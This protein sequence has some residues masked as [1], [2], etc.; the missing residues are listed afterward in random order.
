MSQWIPIQEYKISF[1]PKINITQRK[2]TYF[3]IC[4]KLDIILEKKNIFYKCQVQKRSKINLKLKN[5][6]WKSDVGTFWCLAYSHFY[7][8]TYVSLK[9]DNPNYNIGVATCVSLSSI[10]IFPSLRHSCSIITNVAYIVINQSV[11]QKW[12]SPLALSTPC[13]SLSQQFFF[14]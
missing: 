11:W 2:F 10:H 6:I 12:K 1:W 7:T 13:Q 9:L 3:V 4:Q 5:K 8:F 14:V